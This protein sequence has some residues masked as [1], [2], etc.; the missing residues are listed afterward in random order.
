MRSNPAASLLSSKGSKLSVT[1]VLLFDLTLCFAYCFAGYD[2][3]VAFV[4]SLAYLFGL[5]GRT[6]AKPLTLQD[7]CS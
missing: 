4:L 6:Y 5:R 2:F 7:P 3:L 1:G